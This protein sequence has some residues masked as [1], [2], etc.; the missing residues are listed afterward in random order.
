[1]NRYPGSHH[2]PFGLRMRSQFILLAFMAGLFLGCNKSGDEAPSS[3]PEVGALEVSVASIPLDFSYTAYTRG[4]R[5]IE[6]R[7]RVSGILL[8]RYYREGS[9]VNAGDQLFKIDPAPFAAEVEHAKS[10]LAVAEAQLDEATQQ[11]DRLKSLHASQAV[12][13]HDYNIAVT[14][15]EAAKASVAAARASLKRAE[16]DLGY[17]Q[18]TAPISGFTSCEVRSEGSLVEAG[19]ESSLL[20]TIAQNDRLYVDFSM[21]EDEAR[22]L[23]AV[24]ASSPD[25]VRVR[26]N[27]GSGGEIVD[28]ARIEF[29]DTRV[30]PDTA[31]VAVR[32]VFD[33]KL[34][35]QSN[36]N[37]RLCPGQIVRVRLEGIM[38]A[39]AVHIP[40]RAMMFGADGPYVW[41]LD[42]ENVVRFR[43][44]SLGP[45]RGNLVEIAS[46]LAA[47][48]RVVIDGT[49]KV[50]PDFKAK[51]VT[52][53]LDSRPEGLN[54]DEQ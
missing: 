15:Y 53:T 32:A 24:M 7:S 31:T 18:V 9:H 47:G 14:R 19:A 41:I 13:T 39:P 3:V 45:N 37:P 16:L 6:V 8:K 33:N 11:R 42:K 43:S 10:Q 38:S 49:L 1:M 4:I 23:R 28:T 52:V 17:T 26:L 20:T 46:G 12:G 54:R 35:I 27:V 40:M 22:P 34:D 50:Q 21:P 36:G 25:A 44:V 51:P 2:F 29:I 48:D 30:A 5:E